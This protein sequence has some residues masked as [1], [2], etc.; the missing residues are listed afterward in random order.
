MKNTILSLLRHGLTFGGG[1]LVAKG[2]ISDATIGTLIPAVI[3]AAGA[4]W[5]AVDEYR[6][7]RAAKQASAN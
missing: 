6:A 1:Y 4:V 5:G 7:E 2:L 3:T